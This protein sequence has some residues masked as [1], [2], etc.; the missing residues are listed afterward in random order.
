MS[1]DD[2][3]HGTHAGYQ[4]HHRDGEKACPACTKALTRWRKEYEVRA[5]RAGGRTKVPAAPVRAHLE[6]L[7]RHMTAES[8]SILTGLSSSAI[9]DA[10]A[11]A[12]PNVRRSTADRILAVKPIDLPPGNRWITATGSARRIQALRAIGWSLEQ[13][14]VEMGTGPRN[15][16]V[17][18]IGSGT[19]D[20]VTVN[21]HERI[22]ATYDR[23]WHH[24][25]PART[26]HDRACISA[27]VRRAAARGWVPP[28]AWDDDTIDDPQATPDLGVEMKRSSGGQGRPTEQTIEDV[29]FLLEHEP[30]ITC[31]QIAA[32]LGYADKSGVQNA[33]AAD[34]GNR[35]DLLARLARNAELAA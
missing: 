22:K 21:M 30:A 19:A 18:L 23:L 4:A 27:N 31:T 29:E 16:R 8:I 13:I 6:T 3:R 9:Q 20:R 12:W 7:I 34:R 14:C 1:P 33:L 11:G 5:L 17:K 25:P 2:K 28:M 26:P 32:R 15:S 10:L 35:P 24:A